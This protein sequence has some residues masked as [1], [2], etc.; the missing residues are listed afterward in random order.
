MHVPDTAHGEPIASPVPL[1][2]DSAR[3][4]RTEYRRLLRRYQQLTWCTSAVGQR[5]RTALQQPLMELY[6]RLHPAITSVHLGDDFDTLMRVQ[7]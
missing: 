7:R 4:H 6:R 5:E 1:S 3:H 2:S